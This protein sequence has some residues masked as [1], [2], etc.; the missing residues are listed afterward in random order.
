MEVSKIFITYKNNKLEK[1]CNNI[2]EA[3][4][5]LGDKVGKCLILRITQLES[6]ENLQMVPSFLPYRREKLTN[7]EDRWS[8]RVDNSFRIEFI[9]ID[10][11]ENLSLIKRIKIMEVSKHYE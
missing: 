9:A 4:K 6:F 8:V 1:L 10:L 7:Y 11:N 2:K 3:R 5:T